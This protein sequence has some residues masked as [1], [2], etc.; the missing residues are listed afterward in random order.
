MIKEAAR[1]LRSAAVMVVAANPERLRIIH[2]PAKV[3][4]VVEIAEPPLKIAPIHNSIGFGN[5]L[6]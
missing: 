1:N 2:S 5:I 6:N 3:A 4:V